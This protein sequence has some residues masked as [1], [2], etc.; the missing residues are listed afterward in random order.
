[1][2]HIMEQLHNYV[3]SKRYYEDQP[4]EDSEEVVHIPKAVIHPILFGGDQLTAARTREAKSANVNYY[5]PCRRLDVLIPIAEEGGGERI[6]R[7]WRY[8]LPMFWNSGRIN[9]ANEVLKMHDYEILPALKTQLLCGSCINITL[10][11]GVLK[12]LFSLSCSWTE[13]VCICSWTQGEKYSSG[14][15]Y[16]TLESYGQIMHQIIGSKPNRY[17]DSE[18]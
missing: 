12:A 8:L 17:C 18:S 14:S 9:Y 13:T 1:M 16:G 2:V 11:K 15:V 10:P 7:D 5:D 6:L 3:P 4:S